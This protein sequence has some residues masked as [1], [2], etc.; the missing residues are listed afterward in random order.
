M[1]FFVNDK[2]RKFFN[3]YLSLKKSF[4]CNKDFLKEKKKKYETISLLEKTILL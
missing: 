3:I 2:L 1:S 4:C